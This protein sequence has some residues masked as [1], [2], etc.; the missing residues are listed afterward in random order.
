M[1]PTI[2]KEYQS[3]ALFA[4]DK[5][6][7]NIDEDSNPNYIKVCNESAIKLFKSTSKTIGIVATSMIILLIFPMYAYIFKNDIQLP[8]PVILPFTDL[9]SKNGLTLNLA[10]QVFMAFMGGTGN[11]GIEIIT[12]ILKNNV[13]ASTVAICHSIDDISE[14][15]ECPN[16]GAMS[17]VIDLKFRN[18]LIQIQDLD[19]FDIIYY[20]YYIFI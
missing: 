4:G 16:V 19:R 15:L 17:R 2:K 1:H 9:E 12:C 6:Y 20:Y 14:S 18:I 7:T 11:I 3:L 13:W 8:I 5:I 10:N